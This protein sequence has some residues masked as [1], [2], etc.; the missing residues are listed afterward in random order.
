MSKPFVK[1]TDDRTQ[2]IMDIMKSFKNDKVLV[3]IPESDTERK[4]GEVT[5]AMLL[6]INELGSPV[7]NIPPRP[8]MQIGL[9]LVEGEITDE[10]RKAALAGFQG[11]IANVEKYYNRMGIIASQSIKNVINQ[12]IFIQMPAESTLR[13][14]KSQGFKGTKALI[15]TGQMRN[16]I[17]Y[18]VKKGL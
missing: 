7:N 18:V 13:K 12:Q 16:A 1:V 8:A 15:V 4:E 9:A 3:G 10:M 14:R 17:T 2:E 5:N 6:A 11:G